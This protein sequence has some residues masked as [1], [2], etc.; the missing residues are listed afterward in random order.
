MIFS[1]ISEHW[2]S[3]KINKSFS[4]WSVLLQGVP[5]GFV[6]VPILFNIYINNLF[7]FLSCDRGNF[8]DDTTPY[9]YDKNLEFVV[10]KLENHSDIVIKWF[11]DNYMKMNSDKCHLFIS[12]HKFE[13]LW[14][15]I[16]D[17]KIWETGTVKLLSITIDNEL[18]FDEHLSNVWQIGNYQH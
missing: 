2:Q 15:K 7:Y 5:Q 17:D 4:S 9:V 18:K 6:L 13:H 10:T 11:E 3:A 16:G 8:A 12:G 14:A 1:Y